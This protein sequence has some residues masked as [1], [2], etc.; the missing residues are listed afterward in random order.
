M[1]RK[2]ISPAQGWYRPQWIGPSYTSE[3]NKQQNNQWRHRHATVQFDGDSQPLPL[4]KSV[5]LA[6]RISH[7]T[8]LKLQPFLFEREIIL[9]VR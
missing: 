5:K 4:P 6:T 8:S 7:H 9:E 3:K 1:G 2:Y